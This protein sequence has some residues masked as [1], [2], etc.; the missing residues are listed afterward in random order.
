MN[1]VGQADETRRPWVC[2]VLL[3]VD[4]LGRSG[5]LPVLPSVFWQKQNG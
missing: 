2:L 1:P 5:G 3:A 4:R